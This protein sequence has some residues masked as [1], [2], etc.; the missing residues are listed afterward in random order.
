MAACAVELVAA[1]LIMR[2]KHRLS[3]SA[4][5]R[6]FGYT[7]DVF[8]AITGVQALALQRTVA[9]THRSCGVGG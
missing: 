6:L 1:S 5:G 4:M 2:A 3:R 7:Y 9:G 8:H